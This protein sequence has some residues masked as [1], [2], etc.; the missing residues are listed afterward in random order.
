VIELRAAK[1]IKGKLSVPPSSDLFFLSLSM[2]LANG[3]TARI[4]PVEA[5]P[6][7]LAW[8]AAF[9]PF[10]A[11]ALE[12]DACTFEP[13]GLDDMQVLRLFYEDIPYR[14]FIV[15][16]LL[17]RLNSLVIEGIPSKRLER[18]VR[19]AFKAGCTLRR[20]DRSGLPTLILDKKDHFKIPDITINLDEMHPFLGLAMGLRSVVDFVT[21]QSFSSPIRQVLPSFGFECVVKNTA[22]NKN[23]DS[24][25]RRLRFMKTGKK[26]E[27]PVQ[28]SVSA[29]FSLPSL[30]SVNVSLPGD[31]VFASLM[32]LAKC[33]VVKGSLVIE[34]V[35]LEPWNTQVL[36]LLKNMGGTVGTQ[37][38]HTC[39]F[40][41]VGTVIVQKISIFGRKVECWP[42]WQYASQLPSM[43]VMAAFAQGQTIFRGLDELRE[44][45]PDGVERLIKCI[46]ALGARY[47]E[48]PDG[49]VIE[50]AKQFDG[51]DLSV[52]LP[53]PLSAAFAI[54]ALKCRGT[55]MIADE[56]ILCRWPGFKETLFSLCDF[57]G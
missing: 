9:K 16:L 40:G 39:S 50:G 26:S 28:F 57:K 33:L 7:N 45:E 44:D 1:E 29:N 10:A 56:A 23:E 18:W 3:V 49:M 47:G 13:T 12:Q 2:A 51:F 46:S 32:I 17:G 27:G 14:E 6:R 8:V 41:S 5:T 25:V 30:A 35:S 19:L 55:S 24:L 20:E 52:A 34:N 36:Q 43:A 42:R 11:I 48:M 22:Q 31:D 38:T 37:E 21:D 53:A 54:A 15:F 4:S